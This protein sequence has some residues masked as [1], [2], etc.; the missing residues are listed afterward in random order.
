M[1]IKKMFFFMIFVAMG[2]PGLEPGTADQTIGERFYGELVGI[3]TA[4]AAIVF[5][6]WWQ[7]RRS[8]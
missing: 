2:W 7:S 5:L 1:M 6:Q 8:N 4:M 3:A